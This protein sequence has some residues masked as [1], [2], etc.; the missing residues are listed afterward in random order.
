MPAGPTLNLRI[1]APGPKPAWLCQAWPSLESRMPVDPSSSRPAARKRWPVQ[2]TSD[3]CAASRAGCAG[4]C[5]Q[6]FAVVVGVELGLMTGLGVELGFAAGEA[7]LVKAVGPGEALGRTEALDGGVPGELQ[8]AAN[9][10]TKPAWANR[11]RRIASLPD[12]DGKQPLMRRSRARGVT[13]PGQV[14]GRVQ[15]LDWI[16]TSGVGSPTT[17]MTV[18]DA[19][20]AYAAK[21][22]IDEFGGH[23]RP[24]RAVGGRPDASQAAVRSR[25]AGAEEAPRDCRDAEQLAVEEVGRGPSLPGPAGCRRPGEGRADVALRAHRAHGHQVLAVG[26]DA[27]HRVAEGLVGA[28]WSMEQRRIRD[29]RP[30]AAVRRGPGDGMLGNLAR[31]H[32][33]RCA[34]DGHEACSEADHRAHRRVGKRWR[35]GPARPGQP[36][37]RRPDDRT[38][39]R[40]GVA[41]ELAGGVL[42]AHGEPA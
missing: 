9:R 18:G 10:M 38:N 30:R 21:P 33:I 1:R 27:R 3:V 25:W 4:T 19:A 32:A 7:E 13:R 5:C 6:P 34:A 36:I 23:A 16:D 28:G 40:G 12:S 35:V 41:V 42:L 11:D 24:G 15:M 8:P 29:P 17:I 14:V 20:A 26:R 22:P 39:G 37:G 31:R 2:T